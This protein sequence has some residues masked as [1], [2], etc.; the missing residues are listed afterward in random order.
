MASTLQGKSIR[1]QWDPMSDDLNLIDRIIKYG[2]DKDFFL[3][4]NGSLYYK[5]S[6]GRYSLLKKHYHGRVAERDIG[7]QEK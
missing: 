2:Q 6:P 1:S 5:S 7:E 4:T 3:V